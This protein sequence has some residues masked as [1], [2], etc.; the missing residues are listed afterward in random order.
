MYFNIPDKKFELIRKIARVHTQNEHR[1]LSNRCHLDDWMGWTRD[2]FNDLC[3][4]F[5]STKI[6]TC[7]KDT[8]IT[9]NSLPEIMT[10][11]MQ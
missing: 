3:H 9:G 1:I 10:D 7:P 2:L 6:G 8:Q 4:R 5:W 11:L